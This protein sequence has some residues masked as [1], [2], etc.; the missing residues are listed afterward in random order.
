MPSST[1]NRAIVAQQ[2]GG[3]PL[4]LHRP[5]SLFEWL[6]PRA[7]SIA[8]PLW[9]GQPPL[10]QFAEEIVA[11]RGVMFVPGAMFGFPGGYFRLGLGRRNLP[12]V[13]AVLGDALA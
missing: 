7:G 10:D 2:P 13:L 8:F 6:E 5:P 12:E 11:R 3:R 9:L 4:L 1:R